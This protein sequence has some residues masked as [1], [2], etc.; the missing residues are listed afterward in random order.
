MIYVIAYDFGTSGV[1]AC[2]F[3]ID[4]DI[5][6][7]A[8]AYSSYNLYLLENGG[9]EQDTTEWWQ[10]L[11]FTTREMFTKTDVSPSQIAGISFCAQMQGLVLVDRKGNALRRP[12][13]YMDQRGK[14]E[15]A[16]C[17]GKGL[18]KV[19]GCDAFKLMKNV[20]VNKA[21]SCSVK[22][23]VWKYKWVENN[24]PEI[25]ARVHKWL[26]VKDYL[27]ARC[28]G[29]L[30][31]TEDSAF[32][33]FLYD[34]RPGK[35]GWNA[36]LLKMY[37]VNPAHLP[38]IIGCAE[39]V[40]GLTQKAAEELGLVPGTPVFGG[41]GD[42]PLIGVGAGCTKPG[43]THIYSGT[44]GWVSTLMDKQAVD[45][46]AMITGV[47]GAAKGRYHYFAEMETAGKCLEWARD[48]LAL[49]DIDI[50]REKSHV[51]EGYNKKYDSLYTYLSHVAEGVPPGANGVIFTPWL[52]GNRCPFED[53]SAAGMFFN[54]GLRTDKA[55]M[56]RAVLE[57]VC[58]HMRW[59]LE[60]ETAKVKTS[61]TIRCVG[62][63]ALSPVTC[64][65]LAD[66][67]GRV[68]ETVSGPQDVGA[69]GAALLV[70]VGLGVFES[71]DVAGELVRANDRYLPNPVN[72]AVYDRNY[73]VFKKLYRSNAAHF[74]ALNEVN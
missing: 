42:V 32:G 13:N 70:A 9:A 1:K 61:A 24:E 45:L 22:D 5:K 69:V 67:T 39:Q 25:F 23:P 71:L 29:E 12:M 60:C 10:A 16:A 52:H 14:K 34:T 66:M 44:S 20:R 58:Y 31:M 63:G 74:K 3:A 59:M 65:M 21:A 27:I 19:A 11:C 7:V 55:Q 72:K 28:T 17:M 73:K 36:S 43:Q 57:G 35:E 37:S 18:I 54:L 41:G 33:T 8:S 30:V 64:Q 49:D 6:M 4:K 47:V 56:I 51:A 26:D 38:K 50:Y 68:I 48:H 53:S 46:G 2:I 15:F 62:G 40:G